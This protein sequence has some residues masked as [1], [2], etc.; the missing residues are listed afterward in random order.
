MP[1]TTRITWKPRLVWVRLSQLRL[2]PHSAD[3]RPWLWREIGELA[4]DILKRGL[5]NGP[6]VMYNHRHRTY[7]I[8][9]GV[10]RFRACQ[11]LGM[12]KIQCQV[13]DKVDYQTFNL[14][15]S[16]LRSSAMESE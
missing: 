2:P 10:R 4:D 8:F 14:A 1:T 11:I 9:A 7:T 12:T 6:V 16:R 13:V 5:I 3:I 15:E